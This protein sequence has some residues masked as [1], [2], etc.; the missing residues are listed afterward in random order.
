MALSSWIWVTA[1]ITHSLND[2]FKY[3]SNL[4]NQKNFHQNW[5]LADMRNW[6][7][8]KSKSFFWP[9]IRQL[10]TRPTPIIYNEF[11][12]PAL[13][14]QNICVCLTSK[15]SA[16][17]SQLL[18]NTLHFNFSEICVVTVLNT[19]ILT[20]KIIK[21]VCYIESFRGLSVHFHCVSTFWQPANQLKLLH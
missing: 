11:L 15:A 17:G 21:F 4:S 7:F 18:R 5:K 20:T 19:K 13:Y 6:I 16:S 10:K 2:L 9:E 8:N 14:F 1:T 12:K 3:T